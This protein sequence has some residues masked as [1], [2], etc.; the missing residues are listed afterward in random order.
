MM[1]KK[2]QAL[3]QSLKDKYALWKALRWTEK[4]EPD[5]PIPASY[6]DLAVGYVGLGGSSDSARVE[7][8]C[9][10]SINHA[11]GRQ[12]KTDSQRPIRQHSTRLRA[13]RALR[14]EVEIACARRLLQIAEMIEKET[15]DEVINET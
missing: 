15:G 3:V 6:S 10:S 7:P 2:E 12:D 11:W 4:V 8:S 1:N 5:V 9:S 14:H 13:L